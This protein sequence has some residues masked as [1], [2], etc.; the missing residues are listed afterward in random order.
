MYIAH[1]DAM[2]TGFRRGPVFGGAARVNSV[3]DFTAIR[4]AQ[5]AKMVDRYTK[6]VLTVI[7]AAL[8]GLLVQNAIKRSVAADEITKVEICDSDRCLQL[9]NVGYL[10]VVVRQ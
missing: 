8:V 2:K 10:P 4:S 3:Y 1:N 7:A 5:E 6:A 9:D